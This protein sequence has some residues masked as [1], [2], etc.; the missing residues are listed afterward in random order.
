MDMI[1]WGN[2]KKLCGIQMMD[3]HARIIEID[4][5][6]KQL[7]AGRRYTTE[8]P[9]GCIVNGVITNETALLNCIKA[10]V[11]ALDLQEAHVNLVVPT[12]NLIMRRTVSTALEDEELRKMIELEMLGADYKVALKHSVLNYIRLGATWSESSSQ[13]ITENTVVRGVLEKHKPL[14]QEDVLVIATSDEIVQSYKQVVKKVGLETIT[15]EPALFSLYRGI[16]RHW[17]YLGNISQR[18]V[19]LQTDLGFSEIS[20]FDQGIPVFTFVVNGSDYPS[21]EAYTHYLQM[22]FNRILSYFRHSVF[23]DRTDL[24]QMYLVGEIDWLKKQLQPLGM[25]FEGNM[26]MLSLADLLNTNETIYDPFTTELG[27]TER[28]A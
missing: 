10:M 9:N 14:H 24:R 2:Q 19:L 18:F 22:E 3:T 13:P 11:D 1:N 26:T 21:V 5:G 27:Q 6:G 23:S 12:P 28:G 15:I 7:K 8:L 16:F 20:I 17:R 4:G 25:M